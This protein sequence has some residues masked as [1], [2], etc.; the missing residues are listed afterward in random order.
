M[1]NTALQVPNSIKLAVH[2]LWA[3]VLIS[4][5]GVLV[6]FLDP[7][8]NQEI[9]KHIHKAGNLGLVFVC[10]IVLIGLLLVIF[11]CSVVFDGIKDGKNWARIIY[12]VFCIYSLGFLLTPFKTPTSIFDVLVDLSAI[13]SLGIKYYAVFLIFTSPGKEWFAKKPA[14]E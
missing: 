1:S 5:C 4:L 14:I 10:F 12:L 7:D 8:K 6:I 3:S 9:M 13:A 11:L 2:C